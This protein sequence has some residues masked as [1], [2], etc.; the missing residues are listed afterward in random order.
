MDHPS[1]WLAA[2]TVLIDVIP[3]LSQELAALPEQRSGT[4]PLC[5]GTAF[6]GMDIHCRTEVQ[7]HGPMLP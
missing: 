5:R 3:E 1:D 6:H 4:G 7:K 2:I